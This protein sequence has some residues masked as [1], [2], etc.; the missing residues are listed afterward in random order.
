VI[1]KGNT[2]DGQT[3][4]D[5]AGIYKVDTSFQS[6]N[7]TLI[8]EENIL[9]KISGQI[10]KVISTDY[11]DCVGGDLGAKDTCK[12]NSVKNLTDC[13]V[14]QNCI[15]KQH[16]DNYTRLLLDKHDINIIP[17]EKLSDTIKSKNKFGGVKNEITFKLSQALKHIEEAG[18]TS[19]NY[20]KTIFGWF[21]RSGNSINIEGLMKCSLSRT[22]LYP[23][24]EDYFSENLDY[25]SSL[26]RGTSIAT[27]TKPQKFW[28]IYE[29]IALLENLSVFDPSV[30]KEF[31]SVKKKIEVDSVQKDGND[32][33]TGINLS[34]DDVC[35]IFQMDQHL[36]KVDK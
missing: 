31:N 9:K 16:L 4:A 25:G 7:P 3:K 14:N 5:N 6:H 32:I 11:N 35:L 21:C 15:V 33:Y 36:N 22:G 18:E 29:N 28:E 17:K 12:G 24:S 23:L 30:Q 10:S 2:L 1:H 20:P 19:G 27:K 13:T 26:M 8:D 34:F